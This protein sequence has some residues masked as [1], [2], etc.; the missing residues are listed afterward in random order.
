M[1]PVGDHRYK[2]QY[3]NKA[4]RNLFAAV[5][6]CLYFVQKKKKEKK[7]ERNNICEAQESEVPC[8]ELC[9]YFFLLLLAVFQ[10]NYI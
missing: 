9:L 7:K 10:E 3:L 1:S 6:S 8:N 5:G 4:S 2:S